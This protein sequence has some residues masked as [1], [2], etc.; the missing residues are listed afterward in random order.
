MPSIGSLCAGWKGRRKTTVQP[1]LTLGVH[2]TDRDI[3]LSNVDWGACA[4][5]DPCWEWSGG[6]SGGHSG[7]YGLYSANRIMRKAHRLAYSA[8]VGPIPQG[9]CVCHSCDNRRCVNP[10]HLWIGTQRQNMLDCLKKRRMETGAE[11]KYAKLTEEQ[12]IAGGGRRRA[13][14]PGRLDESWG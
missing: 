10:D 7:G 8:F 6:I 3:V 14:R 2:M 11:S 1:V 4:A 9:K 5:G 12:V 13:L